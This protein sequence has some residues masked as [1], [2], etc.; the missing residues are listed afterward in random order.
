MPLE[1]DTNSSIQMWIYNAK[2]VE[3]IVPLA[4]VI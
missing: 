4:L 1:F 3:K 2:G